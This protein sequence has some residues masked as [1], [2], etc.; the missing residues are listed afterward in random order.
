MSNLPNANPAN[1]IEKVL[2]VVDVQTGFVK[3]GSF[4][5]HNKGKSKSL[6]D[7]YKS[8]EQ[9][10]QIAELISKNKSIV[11]T[12]DFHPINHL[13]IGVPEK[14]AT[15]YYVTWPSHC[16]N[17][18]SQPCIRTKNEE[19]AGL[20][21]PKNGYGLSANN[22]KHCLLYTSPSPRDRTRSRMPSSA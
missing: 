14:V 4:F 11:F 6:P 15:N 18:G 7:I 17:N 5:S 10:C 9:T 1:A 12:R 21:V 3:G 22:M 19:N 20:N 8:I 2:V 13:S 16:T